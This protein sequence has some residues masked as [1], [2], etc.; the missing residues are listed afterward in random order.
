MIL[1]I[2][3]YVIDYLVQYKINFK[4]KLKL[5]LFPIINN[6]IIHIEGFDQTNNYINTT[7]NVGNK[8]IKEL[9][10]WSF[11]NWY[12]DGIELD[13]EFNEW[14]HN[15]T[16]QIMFNQE[17]INLIINI[18]NSKKITPLISRNSTIGDLKDILS[19]KDNIY[20]NKI[21]LKNNKTLNY[22]NINNMDLLN[23]HTNIY[24]SINQIIQF[25]AQFIA[26]LSFVY[27]FSCNGNTYQKCHFQD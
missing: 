25:I 11:Y 1:I 22:Y 20:F 10:A 13:S 4:I 15:V 17:Y 2:L 26:L 21:N 8:M 6:M 12:D 14:E 27:H 16:Y 7:L 24:K 19:I 9:G 23:V 18:N 3:K 5:N